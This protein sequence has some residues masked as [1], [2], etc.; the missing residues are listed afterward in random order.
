MEGKRNTP[1]MKKIA[2]ILILLALLPF[3]RG[4]GSNSYNKRLY[5][6]YV[7][8]EMAPWKGIIQ[9]MS[10]EYERT[11]DQVL[12][13]DLCFA[14]YGYIGYLISEEEEKEARRELDL[15]MTLTDELYEILDG[16]H[17]ALALQGALLG[18]RI[19]LSKFTSMFS[20]PRA[21]KYI[22]TAYESSDIY[23]NCNV[24]MGNMLFYTPKFLGGSQTEAIPYY[25]KAVEIL[26]TSRLKTDRS[27][28]YMN[29]VL[30]LANAYKETGRQDLACQ[31]YKQV[32][33]YE[34]AADWI[35]KDLYSKCKQ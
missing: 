12:L 23:F 3:A 24:E 18:Y 35:R 20:G 8:G 14:Y 9:E 29:T 34:P 7:R 21:M 31:L 1:E 25:Q 11:G 6:S 22:K 32:L 17:D 10:R 19:V 4:Q 2:C 28:I 27:W 5:E 30:L 15:A 26:E 13:Y 33:E 16:R